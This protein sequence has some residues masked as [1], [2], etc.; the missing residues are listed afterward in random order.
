MSRIPP[1]GRRGEGWVLLQVVLLL[2][3]PL[4]AWQASREAVPESPLVDLARAAGGAALVGALGLI[5][6]S[7]T[8]LRGSNALSALPRPLEAGALVVRGPYRYVRHPIYSGLV[9]AGLAVALIRV[10]LPIAVLAVVLAVVL[11]LKR[12]REEV[13]LAERYAGYGPYRARTRALIPFLY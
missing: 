10:S 3:I 6:I 5:A 12:R 7:L 13:W 9:L 1:L 4:A 8:Y 11:D 2:A